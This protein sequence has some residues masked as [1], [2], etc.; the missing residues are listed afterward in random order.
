MSWI[1]GRITKNKSWEIQIETFSSLADWFRFD[2]SINSKTDHAGFR[3]EI[4][5]LKFFYFHLWIVDNRHWD[6]DNN[7]WINYD[8]ED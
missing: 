2:I 5:I 3:F 7:R 4:E 1:A 6:Y 8:H